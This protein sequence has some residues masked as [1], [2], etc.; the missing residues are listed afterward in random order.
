MPKKGRGK[1]K[2]YDK[3][4]IGIGI[5]TSDENIPILHESYPG[6]KHDSRNKSDIKVGVLAGPITQRSLVQIQLPSA[7]F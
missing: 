6:N 1:E 5:A 4:I 3:N 2:R 7:C